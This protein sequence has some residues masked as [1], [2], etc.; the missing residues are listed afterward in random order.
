MS[1]QITKEDF[2]EY[3]KVRRSGKFNMIMNWS[4][5]IAE[6][7]LSYEQWK[8]IM[9]HYQIIKTH[10]LIENNEFI[11]NHEIIENHHNTKNDQLMEKDIKS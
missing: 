10:Q 8:K 2:V 6:T 4:D 9:K 5:A 7:N 3:E 11:E 1:V